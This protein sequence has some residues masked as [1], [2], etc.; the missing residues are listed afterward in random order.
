MFFFIFSIALLVL[1]MIVLIFNKTLG[2]EVSAILVTTFV[3][4]SAVLLVG[5]HGLRIEA[6]N[7]YKELLAQKEYIEANY[8]SDDLLTQYK[9]QD[10]YFKYQFKYLQAEESA[11]A[12]IMSGY[13]GID[14]DDVKLNLGN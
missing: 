14:L 9:V 2:K 8:N 5:G 1:A 3:C 13:W 4:V 6:K 11:S 7:T 12:G 10:E